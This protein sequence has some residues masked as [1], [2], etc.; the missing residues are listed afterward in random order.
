MKGTITTYFENKKYGFIT[1]D[2]DGASRFFHASN[3]IGTPKLGARVEF[4]ISEP[5]K[6]GKEKQCVNVTVLTAQEGG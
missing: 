2:L 6:I 3:Y 5:T 4:T 1:A